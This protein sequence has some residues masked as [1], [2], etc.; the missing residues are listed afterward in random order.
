MS[1]FKEPV[2]QLK[3]LLQQYNPLI[4]TG[5]IPDDVVSRNINTFQ[6]DPN[7]KVFIGTIAKCSTGITLNAASYMIMLDEDWS[8]A[9]NAQC[10]DRIWR[11]TN[12]RPAFITVLTAKDTIDEHV[13]QVSQDKKDLSDYMIDNKPSEK[14]VDQLRSILKGL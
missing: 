9:N 12:T 14:F 3:N 6:N 10:Q 5:D 1:T 4:N 8:Y 13:H 7:S 11:V 2:Y